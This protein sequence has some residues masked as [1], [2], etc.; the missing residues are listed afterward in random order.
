VPGATPQAASGRARLS[1]QM[2]DGRPVQ[3]QVLVFARGT[4]VFQ[5]S[6]VGGALPDEAVETYF[7]SIRFGP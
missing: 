1:G 2:P 4:Q 3:M 5:A 6:V 7:T